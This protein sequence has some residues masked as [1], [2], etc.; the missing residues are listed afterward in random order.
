ML[1]TPTADGGFTL[2]VAAAVATD[3]AG[4]GNTV[5]AQAAGSFDGTPPTVV[6]EGV[7]AQTNGA[8][9]ATIQFSEAVTGFLV[10]DIAA[11]NASLSGFAAVDGDTYTVLV[12]PTTEGVFSLDV[13]A[14]VASDTAANSNTAASQASGD[15]DTTAPTVAIQN[16]PGDTNAPFTATIQFS[17]AVSGFVVGDI[18]AGNAS[19][20]G[21]TSVDGDTYT[22]LVTPTA[23]GAFTLDVNAAVATDGAGNDNTAAP[24]ASGNFDNSAPTVAIQNVPADTNAP[25]TAT[26]QFSEAV[27]GFVIGDISVTNATLSGFIAVD[28]DTYTV[29]VTPTADGAFS[30]DVA[31]SSASDAA[32]NGNSAATQAAGNF[33]GTA[34]TVAIQGV[35]TE[36]NAAFT[37]TIQF[38]EAVSGFA[39]GDISAGN[40]SLSGFTSVDGDTYTVLVTPSSEGAFTLDVGAAVATDTAGNANAASAQAAGTYDVT[41]PATPSL[42]AVSTDTGSNTADGITRDNT[43][44]LSG[45]GEAGSTVE[46][47]LDGTP[48]GTAVVLPL[49]D[50]TLDYSGT[51]LADD[52]YALT[53]RAAD[54]AGNQSPLSPAFTLRVDTQAPGAPLISAASDDTGASSSDGITGDNTLVLSGTA[55]ADAEVEVFRD[56]ASI[57]T[58]TSDGAGNW[59]LD[60]TATSLA[61]GSY[62]LTATATDIAGNTSVVSAGF[63]LVVDTSAPAAPL[64]TGISDDTGVSA[65]DGITSDNTLFLSGTG[66]PGTTLEI[67][68]DGNSVETVTVDAGGNWQADGTDSPLSDGVYTITAQLTDVAGNTSGTSAPFALTVDT[69]APTVPVLDQNGQTL[70]DN[71]PTLTGTAEPGASVTVTLGS[72]EVLQAVADGAGQWSVTAT[73]PVPEGALTVDMVARDTAGNTSATGNAGVTVDIQLSEPNSSVSVLPG[74]LPADGTATATVSVSVRDNLNQPQAGLVLLVVPELG[75]VGAVTDNGNG[76]YTATLTAPL[77]SGTG[78]VTVSA[79]GE[80]VGQQTVTFTP[81]DADNDGLS[82][83]DEDLNGDGDPTND[84]LDG[85]G[86]PNYLDDDDDGDGKTTD[87]EDI[88]NDGNPFND[89]SDGDG[90]PDFLDGDD[91][92]SDGTNDSDGDGIADT[93]ECPTG[94]PCQDTDNDGVPDY[95]DDDDDN[96]GIPSAVE[97]ESRDSDGDGTPDY[98]DPDDDN[99][100]LLTRNEDGNS[101]GDGDPSTM[102]GP[103]LDGDGIPAYLDPNDLLPGV[104]DTDGDGIADDRECQTGGRCEDSDG[105]GLPD[106]NDPDDDNDN[107]PTRD[108][109]VDNDG[110]PANDD[111]DGDGTPNYL[112][113]D[114]DGDGIDSDLEGIGDSD[115]DGIPDYLD[116]DNSGA[117]DG[118]GDSDGDG[119]SDAFECPAGIPCRDSDSDGIPDYLD[120]DDDNDGVLT[121]DEDINEDGDASN[122]DV[123]GDGTPNY[124]DRDDDGDGVD[125]VLEGTGDSDGDGIPDHLDPSAGD[126]DGDGLGD[127]IECPA[128]VP[129]PDLDGNGVPDFMDPDDDGDGVLTADEDLD[130][131]GDPRNEDSDGDGIPDYRDTDDDGDG[132]DSLIE[133]AG[134]SDGDG[135][136]DYLDRDSS[137]APGGGDSDGDGIVDSVECPSGIPCRDSDGDG[138]PDYLDPDD[139]NDG[140]D[141]RDEDPDGNGDPLTD[142]TD[143]DGTPNYLDRDDDGDGIDTSVEGTGDSDG[144]GIPDHLDPSAGDSDGDGIGDGLECPSGIPCRDSDGDGIADYLDDDDD[145]D[146]ILTGNEDNNGLNGPADDDTDGDGIPDYLDPDDDNDGVPTL[147][148][149]TGDADGDNIPDHLDPDSANDAG[150]L[151][152]SGDSDGDGKSDLEECPGGSPCP[153]TDGDGVPDYLDVPSASAVATGTVQTALNSAGAGSWMLLLSMMLVAVRRIR[154]PLLLASIVSAPVAFAEQAE[155][156]DFYVGAG[157]GLSWLEPG[158]GESAYRVA[159]ETDRG[160]QAMAGWRWRDSISLEAF[161]ADL[162]AAELKQRFSGAS[163]DLDYSA[164]G[165][166]ANWYPR[167]N[168]WD[169]AHTL[170]WYLQAGLSSL[171]NDSRVPVDKERGAQL[172]LGA[173]IDYELPRRWLARVSLQGHN[174]DAVFLSVNLLKAF[175]AGEPAAMSPEPE[176]QVRNARPVPQLTPVITAMADADGDSVADAQDQCPETPAGITVNA[177]GCSALDITLEGL[178]FASGSARIEAQSHA[179]LDRVVAAMTQFPSARVEVAAHTDSLG[180]DSYNLDLSRQRAQAVVDYLV[181][182]GVDASRLESRGYGETQPVGDN[183]TAEGRAMNR[184][185][186]V[187]LLA[188]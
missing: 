50:W 18:V 135:I 42:D 154:L 158:T 88:N 14:G 91:D 28:A 9:I 75:S 45:S 178:T 89:D 144:D 68:R 11:S 159:D 35:P 55:E 78:L 93:V 56:G 124:L 137:G 136:P 96:D 165:A 76:T 109:D 60:D 155:P 6:I 92:S 127:G 30:V 122:D 80:A 104:G 51:L 152:G 95:M 138:L 37:A 150:T 84:D 129:C 59:T 1:V 57:G 101:D 115:G 10:G 149:G 128:G 41:P 142:D 17:E 33:D 31:A 64:I 61:D 157:L 99:D 77:V 183:S 23:E 113:R 111:T 27:T 148:E 90:I 168:S 49:G 79:G 102:P 119:L 110:D 34:P 74:S 164:Y 184:R 7:P 130:G 143:Q 131:N 166:L 175:P 186:E 73:V 62:I 125:T 21:F 46:V 44:L 112:D 120:D 16:V 133:G 187:K 83:D 134:D 82:N 3:A 98:R 71:T 66:E 105:D 94:L 40:A 118:S 107:I 172:T 13:A 114:D 54:S 67:F 153:D 170:R 48:I 19:L 81:A 29:L 162:G 188:Q 63:A 123:D 173:G 126:S 177:S 97:G 106:F 171:S 87:E 100:G 70:E 174:V 160:W 147:V 58:A 12:T 32:G 15:F 167:Q 151:D 180:S 145:N 117:I 103:D 169:G 86:T 185:V 72:G 176:P 132:V 8:F 38:S 140:I 5:A 24:Q 25:F 39:V 2:D 156:V 20:S 146:G 182:Q 181:A 4:N 52:T 179:I 53:V 65:S 116:R 161:Y 69:V 26:V 108:E 43:L 163:A 22:V 85:D 141:T 139:D 36:T 47:F 121:A